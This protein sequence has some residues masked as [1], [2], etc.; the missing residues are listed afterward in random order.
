M[1][2][3]AP[4][5]GADDATTGTRRSLLAC[6]AAMLGVL[7]LLAVAC[8][9]F[10]EWLTSRD[11][12]A[13]Y[14]E[15]FARG[16]LLAGIVAAF[17]SGTLAVLRG[18]D[19]HIAATG[20]G[21]ATL[22]LLLGGATVEFDTLQPTPFSLGL[23]W[24]VLSVLFSAIAF[25]PLERT[26]AQRAQRTLRPGWRTDLAYFFASHVLVQAI[27]I[28]VT[29]ST[30]WAAALGDHA[31]VV[32]HGVR[33]LPAWLQFVLAV[34]VADLGQALLHRAYHRVPLLW[35]VHA[36]HHSSRHLDWLA[37]S[38]MHLV[39]I[40]LTRS[41]VLVPLVVIGF[42]QAVV[43]AYV[44]LAGVQAVLAHANLGTRFGWLEH[45]LVLP[46]YHHWHHARD[47]AFV[48][49]HYA[50]HLPVIDRLM[51]TFRL[52]RDGRWPEAYGLL[53]PSE[54][55]EGIVAQHASAFRRR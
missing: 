13:L 30:S 48:D 39:E 52:P 22:A 7:A 40:V 20:V 23:D 5:D 54:V 26:F 36:I 2:T 10:P 27:L 9:H 50:I 1:N 38:R 4:V 14:S 6:T 24:F 12:R 53:D 33:A 21:A 44:V 15:R 51:G 47:R 18:R 45:V 37:G 34:F 28:A 43:N 16:L 29:A 17:A 35:R 49:A 3:P 55:P 19:R 11:I 8:F 32:Q 31:H 25:V 42:E 46:R 41:L